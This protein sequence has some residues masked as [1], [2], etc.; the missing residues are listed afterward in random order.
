VF[1]G[2]GSL[3]IGH[4][5]APIE[6][7]AH[8]AIQVAFG[9]DGPI[10]MRTRIAMPW[11]SFS[12]A[13]VPPDLPHEYRATGRHVAN[14]FFEPETPLGRRL[15][16]RFGRGGLASIDAEEAR[17]VTAPLADAFASSAADEILE[18]KARAVLAQL[19]GGTAP[20]SSTDSRVLRAT[21]WIAAHL[22]E[23]LTLAEAAAVAGLS[24]GRFRHL[25]VAETGIAFRPYVLWSRLNRA[26]EL[27]FGGTSWTEAAHAAN[28]ADSAHLTRTCRRM[29]GLAPTSMRIRQAAR[30]AEAT[31]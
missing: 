26:L 12:G 2:G 24:E 21:N 17:T 11:G 20:R 16:E 14:V 5:T 10:E 3:W 4:A 13:L 22:D 18:E 6:L 25:F 19:G 23:P 9:L 29:F 1:W 8:H 27:G 28:F 31:A 7:H 30:A 15:L